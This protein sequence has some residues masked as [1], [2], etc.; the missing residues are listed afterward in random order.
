MTALERRIRAT[1]RLGSEAIATLLRAAS[2]ALAGDRT[3][4]SEGD[5]P[6]AILARL[7]RDA[8][9]ARALY[10][11]LSGTAELDAAFHDLALIARDGGERILAVAA[12]VDRLVDE[13]ERIGGSRAGRGAY[14]RQQ[15][16]AALLYAARR[17]GYAVPWVPSFLEPALFSIGADIVIDFTVAH[18][19]AHALWQ[20]ELTPAPAGFALRIAA[21]LLLAIR[22]GI[23]RASELLAGIAWSLVLAANRLA[24]SLRGM[25]DRLVAP[26]ATALRALTDL[27]EF[28][29]ANPRF[30]ADLAAL[31]AIATRQAETLA[32][33]GGAEKQAYVRALI[34]IVLRQQGIVGLSALFDR[35]IETAVTV[36]IDATVALFNRRGLFRPGAAA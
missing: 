11:S 15:V 9:R 3:D 8:A 6:P 1:E 4:G 32:D 34:L 27:R 19:N 7:Q 16:K 31:F 33:L 24:P 29:T 22:I 30:G 36:G 28:L 5:L 14:K 17:G 18:V 25:V 12:L 2:S 13:A 21:P 10:E 26:D 23:R 35:I 20:R